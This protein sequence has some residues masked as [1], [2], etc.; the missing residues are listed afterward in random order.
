MQF[1]QR[2]VAHDGV[3]NH[4]LAHAGRAVGGDGHR[5]L[6]GVS[7]GGVA[8]GERVVGAL[9]QCRCIG[10]SHSG[11][12]QYGCA[13]VGVRTLDTARGAGQI[14]V[15]AVGGIGYLVEALL[16]L[17]IDEQTLL[18]SELMRAV[19][20]LA[21][22]QREATA[23]AGVGGTVVTADVDR[24]GRK[25]TVGEC[26]PDSSFAPSHHAAPQGR[27][28]ADERTREGTVA[29]SDRA[30][31]LIANEWSTRAVAAHRTVKCSGNVAVV[32]SDITIQDITDD[33]GHE[34]LG[35]RYGARYGQVLK[36]GTLD[37]TEQTYDLLVIR[38]CVGDGVIVAQERTAE[39]MALVIVGHGGGQD[40]G[41]LLEGDVL[42]EADILAGIGLAGIDGG[43]EADPFVPRGDS[44]GVGLCAAA[45]QAVGHRDGNLV[46]VAIVGG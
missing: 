36:R 42:Q 14:I 4:L 46:G 6:A 21:E 29:E 28:L 3:G 25:N 11:F 32:E 8:V 9:G 2:R 1:G 22:G 38:G 20:A 41:I 10:G 15:L 12:G 33:S 30:I 44:V 26:S 39:H 31:G 40:G 17:G 35:G 7:A 13:G 23:S 34:L 16:L 24:R 27:V 18:G 45:I 19:A 43:K 5:L 37:P